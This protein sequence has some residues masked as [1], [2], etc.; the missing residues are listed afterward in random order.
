[1]ISKFFRSV[2]TALIVGLLNVATVV[3]ELRTIV[4]PKLEAAHLG[5]KILCHRPMRRGS[6]MLNLTR[7]GDKIIANNYGHGGSGWTLAPGS[8][9]HVVD[10]LQEEIGNESKDAPVA[11][12]GAGALGLF[13]AIELL[14]RGYTNI[15]IIAE[16]FDDLTSHNAGGL[17]APVSMDNDAKTQKIIDK[18]GIDAYKFYLR[19]AMGDHPFIKTGA[20]IIPAYFPNREDSGLEPF[21]GKVM[22][23][24]KEVTLDFGNG[25]QRDMVSYDDGIFMDTVGLMVQM[26]TYLENSSDKATVKFEKRKVTS[27][28][29]IEQNI[30]VNCTGIGSRDLNNDD[31]LVSVQGHLIMLKDQNPEDLDHMILVYFGKSKNKSG[32]EVKRSFYMFPKQL[33]GSSVRDVGV[34]GG[35]FIEDADGRNPNKEEFEILLQGAKE[36]Y[37]IKE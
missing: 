27:F 31:Q 29:A 22:K 30:I 5:K 21:V 35:T 26:K 3:A 4:P 11:V 17:L 33:E 7:R 36:F 12:L 18:I 1:M 24:A 10:L 15:T 23:K 19:V 20:R 16:S 37:G 32:F 2:P 6:P 9:K 14:E 25:T 13:S 28:D 34:I 8:A